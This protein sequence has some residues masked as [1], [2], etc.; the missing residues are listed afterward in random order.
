MSFLQELQELNQRQT[1]IIRDLST[2]QENAA[3][4]MR[5]DMEAEKE[6]LQKKVELD[7]TFNRRRR[8]EQEVDLSF[9]WQYRP[10]CSSLYI[11]TIQCISDIYI[12]LHMNKSSI[13]F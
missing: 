6:R 8:E 1:A 11:P 4:E 12:I 10:R 9:P 7:I 13:E 2:Q 5:A 3:A